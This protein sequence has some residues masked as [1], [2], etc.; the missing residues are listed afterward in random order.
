[1][2]GYCMER[3]KHVVDQVLYLDGLTGTGKTMMGPLLGSF[4]RVEIGR[5]DHIHEHLCALDFLGKI[6][7]DAAEFMIKMYADLAIYNSMISRDTNF[8]PTD[9]SGIFR[10]P[11]ALEY[12]GRLFKKDG[13]A[14]MSRLASKRPILHIVAH[15]VLGIMDLSLRSFGSR[16]KVVEMVRHPLYLLEHWDS[17]IERHGTDPRDFTVWIEYNKKSL[18][19]FAAGWEDRYLAS[20]SFDKVIY[21]LDWLIKKVDQLLGSLNESQK[22]QIVFIPFEHFVLQPAPYLKN[23]ESL[24]GVGMTQMTKKILKQQKVPRT[25]VTAGPALEIYKKYGWK[26]PDYNQNEKI[27]FNKK[28]EFAFSKASKAAL[29]VL[30]ALCCK[31]EKDNGLWF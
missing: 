14:V 4:E 15:Q 2:A 27:A 18:P 6:D 24:L 1:M 3:E 30:E 29:P 19:W 7:K 22:K 26:A 20:S 16:V 11:Y 23:I 25:R 21:S 28:K 9:L 10:N 13:N 8:R 12:I 5:F 31:Y 17:Y